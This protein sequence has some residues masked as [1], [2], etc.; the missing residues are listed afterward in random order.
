MSLEHNL[1]TYAYMRDSDG[2]VM[3]LVDAR[4]LKFKIPWTLVVPLE[5]LQ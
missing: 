3:L 4:G 1:W 5:P 2:L